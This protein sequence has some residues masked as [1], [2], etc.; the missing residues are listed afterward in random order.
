[1]VYSL[2]SEIIHLLKYALKMKKNYFILVFMLTLSLNLK[3][4]AQ[5]I[6]TCISQQN[7]DCIATFL[8][9]DVEITF[10]GEKKTLAKAAMLAYFKDIFQK[11]PL[12]SF[13]LIDKGKIGS[14]D[15]TINK[16]HSDSSSFRVYIL[17]TGKAIK[18]IDF[19]LIHEYKRD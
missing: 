13:E 2:L 17:L 16:Y 9:S 6:E 1:M 12:K 14:D 3:T 15:Y 7:L 10:Q 19:G 4:Q 11:Y 8:V 18:T 5:T